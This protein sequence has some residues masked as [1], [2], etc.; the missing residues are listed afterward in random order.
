VIRVPSLGRE[1]GVAWVLVGL[2]VLFLACGVVLMVT[3]E[4]GANAITLPVALLASDLLIAATLISRWQ[5]VRPIAQGL[6][7][8]GTLVH[9]LV[10]MRNGP[11]WTR[12][13]A[14]L[15]VVAHVQA[16]LLLFRMT[17]RERSE[18]DVEPSALPNAPTPEA[19]T[20]ATQ[21]LSEDQP[22]VGS[23]TSEA[24]GF[25]GTL[26][27]EDETPPPAVV[28]AQRSATLPVSITPSADQDAPAQPVRSETEAEEPQCAGTRATT[29]GDQTSDNEERAS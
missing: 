27:D 19:P 13:C 22:D 20:V 5:L 26:D 10:L 25:P 29:D 6:A 8:F 23:G 24:D 14:G 18:G 12:A 21:A 15:L 7:I 16:M 3:E 17:I 28:P 1:K 2:A 11:L 4:R 9:L